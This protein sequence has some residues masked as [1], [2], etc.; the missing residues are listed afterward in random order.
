MTLEIH[1]DGS[2]ND[3]IQHTQVVVSVLDQMD[4]DQGS[5]VRVAWR[6]NS[7]GYM[8]GFML[9]AERVQELRETSS[10]G[11]QVVE[12]RCWET[13][14]GWLAPAVDIYVGKKL[15]WGFGAWMD[16][17]KEYSE[18]QAQEN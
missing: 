10:D 15:L 16:G 9:R 13:F 17:L 5:V 8:P 3:N 11:Q 18:K 4:L 14:Y 7:G 1:L 2:N 12:Y 6:T